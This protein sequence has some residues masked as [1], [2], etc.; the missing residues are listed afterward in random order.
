MC[1]GMTMP[2]SEP[3]STSAQPPGTRRALDSHLGSTHEQ[4]MWEAAV[5]CGQLLPG[6]DALSS[7]LSFGL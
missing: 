6:H 7:L 1:K 3:E 2:G 4:S 5:V